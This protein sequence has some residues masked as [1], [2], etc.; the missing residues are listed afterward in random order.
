MFQSIRSTAGHLV[1]SIGPKNT[2]L[3]EDVDISLTVKFRWIPI[4][5]FRG[6]VENVS[7]NQRPGRPFC[8]SIRPEN[9][10]LV[11]YIEILL[12]V[13]FCWIPLSSFREEVNQSCQKDNIARR[14]QP[15]VNTVYRKNFAPVLFSPFFWGQIQNWVSWIIHKGLY[16][17]TRERA[18]SRLGE[19]VSDL[20]RAKIR[21]GKFKAVY[22]SN[23]K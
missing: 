5:G 9:T 10:N 18:N 16:N 4:S 14:R 1:F 8:F 7:A 6:G 17:K 11:D 2:N 23:N 22:S 19:S 12:P 21:L 13:K 3:V 20:C 15:Y